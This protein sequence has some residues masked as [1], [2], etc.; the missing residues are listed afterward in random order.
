MSRDDINWAVNYSCHVLTVQ[1]TASFDKWLRKP[2][3]RR[4]AARIASRVQRLEHG[5]YGDVKYLADT[6]LGELRLD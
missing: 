6:S 4:A 2:P 1:E 3:D 5:H